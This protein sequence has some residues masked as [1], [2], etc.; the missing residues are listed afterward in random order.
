MS[1]L[2]A[3][4]RPYEEVEVEESRGDLQGGTAA[5]LREDTAE[6]KAEAAAGA[7][8]LLPGVGPADAD[9][10][11]RTPDS[12]RAGTDAGRRVGPVPGFR[13]GKRPG[14]ATG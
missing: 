9:V 3:G 10:D 7:R 2:D 5:R 4:S 13:S 14:T 11:R 12:P 1:E 6:A 8:I